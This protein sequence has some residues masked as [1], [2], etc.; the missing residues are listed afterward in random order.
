MPSLLLVYSPFAFLQFGK[1]AQVCLLSPFHL[2]F[3]FSSS[4]PPSQL[5]ELVNVKKMKLSRHSS[6]IP[7][8][9]RVIEAAIECPHLTGLCLKETSQGMVTLPL[10]ATQLLPALVKLASLCLRGIVF[11]GTPSSSSSSSSLR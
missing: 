5:K 6:A 9:E 10:L 2:F 7:G 1:L 3:V 4:S 11:T 8:M